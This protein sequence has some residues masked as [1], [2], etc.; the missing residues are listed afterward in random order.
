MKDCT[1]EQLFKDPQINEVKEWLDFSLNKLID[2]T[3]HRLNDEVVY[4]LTFEELLGA[5]V[6]AKC[7]IEAIEN[8]DS[9]AEDEDEDED[10]G[11]R[12]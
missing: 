2:D 11:V 6:S 7:Y 9:S 12:G 5:L 4:S 8:D 10:D 1:R 3:Q